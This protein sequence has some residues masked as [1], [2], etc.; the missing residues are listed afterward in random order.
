[1]A[2]GEGAEGREGLE[3]G[4]IGREQEPG[5]GENGAWDC[6]ECDAELGGEGEEDDGEEDVEGDDQRGWAVSELGERM[7]REPEALVVAA[8]VWERV[9][10][11]ERG[12]AAQGRGHS[13]SRATERG[14]QGWKEREGGK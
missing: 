12:E 14:G 9:E 3:E 1:L 7:Q 10:G 5:S 11:E 13:K 8:A 4:V 2:L 6:A